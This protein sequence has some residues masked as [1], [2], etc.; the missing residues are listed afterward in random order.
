[1]ATPPPEASVNTCILY[2]GIRGAGKRSCLEQVAS[3]LRPDHRGEKQEVPTRS[4]RGETY[5]V[6]PIELGKVGGVRTRI[7]MVVALG[8]AE[9]A[10]LRRQLLDRADGVVFV[11]DARP[12][13][14]DANIAALEELR[15]GLEAGARR[16]EETPLVVQY[17]KRDL[18]DGYAI[19]EVHRRMQLG[20]VATIESVASEGSGVLEGL[21][22]ISK[23]VVRALREQSLV[24]HDRE[25]EA[26]EAAAQPAAFSAPLAMER[27]IR[28]EAGQPEAGAID[29]EVLAAQTFFEAGREA[30]PLPGHEVA[31][32]PSLHIVSVGEATQKDA[33]TLRVP[34]VLGDEQGTSTR[35]ELSIRI[36]A[37]IQDLPR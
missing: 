20:D 11:V 26:E 5:P 35:I 2:W 17:N 32:D 19:D 9:H 12:E 10:S 24:L 3:K 29:S 22:T 13:C 34:L 30:A 25:P 18:S 1:M 15:K 36:E 28:S 7:D 4:E 16:L 33:A 21:S 6:L 8:G 27:A 14:T 37:V 23:M 31:N